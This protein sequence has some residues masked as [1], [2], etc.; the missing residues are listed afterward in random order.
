ML[1]SQAGSLA[2]IADA[3]WT[4]D[5]AAHLLEWAGF[6]DPAGAAALPPFEESGLW[7]PA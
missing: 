2:P 6:G 5:H 3:N 4:P 1:M 7:D